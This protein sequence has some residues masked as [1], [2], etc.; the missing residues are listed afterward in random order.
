LQI[1][2]LL[3]WGIF[4]LIVEIFFTA[5]VDLFSKRDFNLKGHTSLWMFPI[6]SLGLTY[7]FD[8]VQQIIP[9]D[10][11]RYLS[12]P[13]WI[14]LIEILVGYPASKIGI[15][16]WDYRYLSNNK[17]WKGIISF[18]HFPIWIIFGILVELVDILFNGI[19]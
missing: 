3:F 1:N 14:W 8:V 19:V 9:N 7:G 18:I 6:Y 17:H 13:L 10:F 15:R 12:Y 11:I 16:I 5:I 2:Q 4:G